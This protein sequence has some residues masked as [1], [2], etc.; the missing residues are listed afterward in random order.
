[1]GE[2]SA[3]LG[4]GCRSNVIVDL[5]AFSYGQRDFLGG[6]KGLYVVEVDEAVEIQ[7]VV[8]TSAG[9]AFST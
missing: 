6:F 7:E 3:S 2:C 9:N 1:M 4:R 8:P 5:G